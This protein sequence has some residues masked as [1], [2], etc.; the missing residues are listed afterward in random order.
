MQEQEQRMRSVSFRERVYQER[1]TT[2]AVKMS[3]HAL[4]PLSLTLCFSVPLSVGI[5]ISVAVLSRCVQNLQEACGV[6][7]CHC[8]RSRKKSNCPPGCCPRP[9]LQFVVFAA[10]AGWQR[11]TCCLLR[12]GAHHKPATTHENHGPSP[13]GCAV[14]PRRLAEAVGEGRDTRCSP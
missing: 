7:I 13:T 9:R 3:T 1:N 6:Q 10:S 2:L 8:R 11:C 12:P 4:N 5:H 14:R